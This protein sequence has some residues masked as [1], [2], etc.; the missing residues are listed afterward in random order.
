MK[1]RAFENTTKKQIHKLP[2]NLAHELGPAVVKLSGVSCFLVDYDP[3]TRR[4]IKQKELRFIKAG[5]WA[6]ITHIIALRLR[7]SD[8]TEID[9]TVSSEN[10]YPL[11]VYGLHNTDTLAFDKSIEPFILV[12]L[13][14]TPT[15]H[16][17]EYFILEAEISNGE[18]TEVAFRHEF[19]F[20][21]RFY[22]YFFDE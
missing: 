10:G 4:A 6:D 9:I 7:R 15:E 8:N 19:H 3:K 17:T 2:L 5:H 12:R 18:Q 22:D 13:N 16:K 21:V 14:C 1:S 20:R 11:L